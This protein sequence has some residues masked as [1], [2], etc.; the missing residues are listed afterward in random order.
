MLSATIPHVIQGRQDLN[1]CLVVIHRADRCLPSTHLVHY[2]LTLSQIC[3][4]MLFQQ[5]NT[6]VKTRRFPTALF[7]FIRFQWRSISLARELNYNTKHAIL[8]RMQNKIYKNRMIPLECVS[9]D[10]LP[11]FKFKLK[12]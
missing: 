4:V 7:S 6:S 11:V 3:Y 2:S 12:L 5:Y 1:N 10:I 8:C 9:N